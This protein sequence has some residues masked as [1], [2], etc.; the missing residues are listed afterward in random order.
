MTAFLFPVLLDTVGTQ[1][2]LYGLIVTSVVGA[3]VTWFFR[4]ETTGVNLDTVN[5]KNPTDG[6]PAAIAA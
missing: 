4:I 2:L 6:A 5:K 1:V 3:A